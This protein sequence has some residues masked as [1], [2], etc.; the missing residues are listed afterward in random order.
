MSHLDLPRNLA[1]HPL[2]DAGVA[3]DVIDLI[4][5][6]ED[7]ERGCVGLMLCDDRAV[8]VQPVVIADV[9]AD[10]RPGPVIDLFDR[11]FP[12]VAQDGGMVVFGR[13]RPGSVLVTDTDR[14]WHQ[15]VID[16]CRSH[17]V[18]LLGAFLATPAAVRAFP[19]DLRVV[20]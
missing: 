4:L 3:A 13:G 14:W 7:R 10:D 2:D 17:G 11:I 12:E 15:A 6:H 20:T 19:P 18:H 8:G 1:M 5:G 9:R 16:A